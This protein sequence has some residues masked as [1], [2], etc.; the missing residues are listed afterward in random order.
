VWPVPFVVERIAAAGEARTPQGV[1][2][3]SGS[4]LWMVTTEP[5][6][7][8][9]FIQLQQLRLVLMEHPRARHELQFSRAQLEEIRLAF[10]NMIIHGEE[11]LHR[12]CQ[13]IC[14]SFV[15]SYQIQSVV[16]GEVEST[17]ERFTVTQSVSARDLYTTTDIDLGNR[18]LNKLRIFDGHSWSTANL[19][20]NMVDYQPTEVNPYGIHKI[21]SRIKAEQEIWNKVVDEIFDLDS[22]VVR[23]K[24]LRH[25]SRYVKDVFGIKIVV[26]DVDDAHKVHRALGELTWS[27]QALAK[28]EVEPEPQ[29]NR[30]HFIEVKDYLRS[31]RQKQSGWEALKSVVRWS[32]KTFEIQIQPLGNFLYERE[33]LTNERHTSFR[34]NRQQVRNQ[35]A[36]QIP[37]FCFYRDLLRWLF[38]F[39][40]EA[41]PAYPGVTL[42]LVD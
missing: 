29:S 10:A 4:P 16:I 14:D 17:K 11:K 21:I 37:Q 7:N 42:S 1:D 25:L 8:E 26:G 33:L 18:Q 36:E 20:A 32:D 19:V 5:I 34:A 30:L 38:L 40:D 28:F 41:P 12:L 31:N 27:D 39:P 3:T 6:L 9:L 23:D 13:L 35:V 15:A 22:I 2:S 24:Q